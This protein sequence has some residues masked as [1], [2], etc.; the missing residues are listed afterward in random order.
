M[1]DTIMDKGLTVHSPPP[2][3]TFKIGMAVATV[4]APYKIAPN[5]LNDNSIV[6]KLAFGDSTFL[7]MGDAEHDLETEILAE[8]VDIS[9]KVMKIGHHGS[10][11]STG[12]SF[13]KAVSPQISVISVGANNHY[14]HPSA[15]VLKRLADIGS[16]IY[17]T[18]LHGNISISITGDELKIATERTAGTHSQTPLAA[19]KQFIGNLRSKKFHFPTCRSLPAEKN[20]IFLDSREEAIAEG[21]VPCGICRP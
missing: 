10:N 19:E 17:R 4:L 16:E 18:D 15:V 2:G 9:S 3:E 12:S 20:R 8:G 14:N 1:L 5:N 7:F 6:L 21:Y 11:S 13:L